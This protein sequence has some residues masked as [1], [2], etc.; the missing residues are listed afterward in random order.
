MPWARRFLY[1]VAVLIII[2][3]AALFAL[4]LF[5]DDLTRLATVPPGR[6]TPQKPLIERDYAD[7]RL[8]IAR[9]GL[10]GPG[11]AGAD[12]T[13]F[14][15]AGA[16]RG[17]A[18]DAAVFFIHPTSLLS[19]ASW[20]AAIDDGDSRNRA[21][22]FTRGLAS[23]FGDAV[24]VWAPRYRQAT[25]GAFLTD[26][27]DAREALN[28]A[29]GDV[30]AAFDWFAAHVAPGRPIVLV[31]HS[32]GAM[33]LLRL[34]KD[35]IAGQPIAARIAAAYIIGWPVS[36][37]HDLPL[38]GMPAC[39]RPNQAACVMSWESFAEPATP[40]VFKPGFAGTVGL[41][42]KSRLDTSPVC[43]NPL[44]GG[45]RPANKDEAAPVSANLGTLVLSADFAS[46]TLVARAV[47][48]RCD[49]R[50]LLLIGDSPPDLGPYVL[51]GNNY[52]VYD[53]PLFWANLRAD[54]PARV[55]VW[56]AAK[57]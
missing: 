21:E 27:P 7:P 46:A 52:H 12:P 40:P 53:I 22:F 56:R 45:A 10:Y 42:G 38:T 50:G 4:R 35:R 14:L 20:N 19:R 51:P 44:T 47:P 36:A 49:A 41:D 25:F 34:L 24:E 30:L 23:P 18:I 32:Q 5:S 29:Y 26:R 55:A 11:K 16:S 6:F 9:P 39:T 28:L 37:T 1:G 57:R 13:R 3:I 17:A 54:W 43:T 33:H 31:G 2:V 15:P 48:A 8:W